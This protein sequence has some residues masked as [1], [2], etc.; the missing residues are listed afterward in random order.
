MVQAAGGETKMIEL[1]NVQNAQLK[2][3]G[4]VIEYSF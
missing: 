2:S 4:A 3:K 1:L